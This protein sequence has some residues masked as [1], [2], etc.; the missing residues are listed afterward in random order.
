MVA[1]CLMPL[2][3]VMALGL[4]GC[5][6]PQI[7]HH[8]LGRLDKGQSSREV[9]DALKLPPLAVRQT[10]FKGKAY[11]FQKYMMNN[12]TQRDVYII[13]F[14]GEQ[15]RYWGYVDE[16]RRQPDA[17]LNAALQQVLSELLAAS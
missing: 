12:G 17:D 11:T 10:S 4:A 8:Q 16:F 3:L 2:A 14:E 13:A 1:R 15:L 9:A 5:A 7:F 6:G